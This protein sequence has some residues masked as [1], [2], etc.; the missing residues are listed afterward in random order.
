MTIS[1]YTLI[2][3]ICEAGDL[4]LYQAIRVQNGLPVLLKVPAIQ[5][6]ASHIISRL[7]NEYELA[8]DLDSSHIAKP[9]FLERS[10][11]HIA[12]VL[13][14]GPD[15]TLAAQLDSPMEIPSFLRIAIGITEALSELHRHD[16]V[17]KDLKP[18]HVL[19]DTAGHV[20]LTGLGIA[21]R[22][23]S[24]RQAPEP[25]EAIA[26]TLAYMAPE[27]TGRM[28]RLI[29]F[30]SDLYSLGVI[31]YQ[32]LT[33][34][35]P[36][37]ASDAMEWV[38]CHIARKP[39][40]P[41]QLV[42]GLPEPLSEIVM[43]L[44]AKTAEERY[45][46]ADGLNADLHHSLAQWESF[47]HIDHFPLGTSD[48]S[49]RLLIPEK[50]YGRK[51]E[52]DILMAAFDR[53]ASSGISELV[54]V[55][56]YSG[57]GKTSI[58]HELHKALVA[59]RGLFAEGKYEQYKRDV[60]YAP[61]VQ[62]IQ[63]LIR[64]ILGKSETEV[65]VWRESL[66][67]AVGPNGQLIVNLIPEVELVIG[68]QQPVAELPP[69][70]AQNR[71]QMVLR[72]FLL[73]FSGS[74]HPL[75]IFLDDLQW[76]DAATLELLNQIAIGLQG[77]YILLIGAYRDNEADPEHPLMRTLAALR[78]AGAL[79]QEIV[80]APLGI[81]DVN[82]LIADSL[83]CERERALPLAQLVHEKTGGNPFFTIQFLTMLAEEKLLAFDPGSRRWTW[84]LAHINAKGYTDNVV[85]LIDGK[86]G[87]LPRQ[88]LEALELLACLGNVADIATLATVCRQTEETLHAA[89]WEAVHAGLVFRQEKTYT[90]LHDRVQEAAYSQIPD[91][92]RKSVHWRIGKIL[93]GETSLKARDE[94]YFDIVNH[95][96]LGYSLLATQE[97]TA[98]LVELNNQAGSNAKKSA[99]FATAM[100]YF[101]TGLSLLGKGSWQDRYFLAL[102]LH[103]E[104]AEAACLCGR[105]DRLKELGEAVHRH[106][107]SQLDEIPMYETEIRALTAQGQLLPAI[108]LGLS[109]L[110]GLG[111]PLS[112]EPT[113]SEV[114]DHLERTLDLLGQRTIEG[115]PNL[116]PMTE[117][118]QLACIRILSVLGEPAYA[119]SPQFFLVWASLMAELSLRYGNGPLSPFAYAAYALALCAS[120]RHI[121][122]GSNL[123][124]TALALIEPMEARS[125]RCRLLN[126]YGCT[127]QPWSENL[128]DTLGTLQEAID[129]GAES[130]DFTS[131]SYA[132][133]NSCTAALFM[134][135]PLDKL[136]RRLQANMAIIAGMGQTYI[137]NW[138]AF[139]LLAV[140]RL[141]GA[142]DRPG[143]LGPFD[144]GRWLAAATKANDRCGLAY[145][146]LSKL[147][148]C[149]LLGEANPGDALTCLEGIKANQA[150]FQAAFAVPV[151]YFFAS[152]TLLRL[153]T[154]PSDRRL[155]DVREYRTKLEGLARLAPM[156][157]QHKC[158]LLA[159]ELARIGGEEW[160][161]V[162][163][164]EQAIVGARR[165]GFLHEEAICCELT[166]SF[167]SDRGL[168][169]LAERYIRSA[170]ERY[171]D[172]QAWAK[173]GALE[174]QYP[175]WL[176]PQPG[177][178]SGAKT[179]VLDLNT[180]MKAA[181]T[182]SSEIEMNRLLSEMM[183]IVIENAGARRGYLLLSRN[184]ELSLA[185]AARVENQSVVMEAREELDLAAD[186]L[187]ASILNY[188]GRS[189]DNVL[190]DDAAKPN[191]YSSD[192]YFLRQHPKSVLCFPVVK[193]N[194]LIGMLYLENDLATHAFTPDRLAVLE[195]IVLQAAISLEN[196]L[197]YEA[198]QE[199]EERLKLTLEATQIGIFD[200]DVEQ[201]QWLSSPVYYSMLGYEP[202]HGPGD[203][204]EWLERVHPDD[205][206]FVEAKI[207]EALFRKP[208]DGSSQ[209]YE[210]EARIRHADGSYRWQLV[211]SVA[212]K[213]D[214][215]GKVTRILGI[216]MD[217][218]DRKLMEEALFFVAQ[219]GWQTS[220]ENFFDALAQF[221]GE[222]LDM[223]YVFIDR[224]DENPDM[225]ETVALYA[226]GAIIPNM[227][228]AL[229]GTP[230]ENVMGK[231]LCVY[232]HGIQQ[233]FPED[234][235][236]PGMGAESYIGIPLWDS[237]GQPIG[238]IAVMDTKP[239]TNEVPATQVLQLVATRAA[240]ELERERSNCLLRA[241]EHEFRTLAENLPDNIMRYDRQGRAV[242]L[243]PALEKL[244]G[245]SDEARIGKR[246]REFQTDGRY[247][248]YAQA[249]DAV[250]TSGENG[251]FELTLP[252]PSNN[253]RVYQM[254]M[255]AERDEHGEVTG[256]LV[257]G[258]DI[259]ERKQVEEELC[260]LT[261]FQQT[262]LNSAPYSIISTTPDGM[263]T[264]FNPAAERLLGYAA[265]EVV[266]KQ[267]PALWHDRQEIE[268][269]AQRL[270]EELGETIEPGFEVFTARPCRSQPEE[271]EW[272][273]IHKNGTRI[274]VNLSIT[275]LRDEDGRVSGYLGM[276]YDLTERKQVQHQ[277]QLLTY[278]LDQVKET[279]FLM[280]E[281]DPQFMYVNQG[282]ARTLGYSRDELMSGMG[283]NDIDPSWSPEVSKKYWSELSAGRQ[284]Q[285]ESTHRT[286][287][288]RVFPVEITSNCF[289]FNAR[290][291]NL[292]ICRD[293]TERKQ[294]E[295]SLSEYAAII[296]STDDA[297][298]GKSLDGVITSWNKGAERM[299]GYRADEIVGLSIITL[300]PKERQSEEQEILGKIRRGESVKHYET[301][302]LC[303]DGCLIDVSITVSP[304]KNPL[305]EIIGA[306][307][308]ARDIT[309][310]KRAETELRRYRDQL[311][312]T[313]QQRTAE[314]LL[315]RDAAEAANKAKSVFL[316]N[317]SHELRTPLNAILGFSGILIKKPLLQDND[318]R[319][320]EIINH[321]GEH[322]LGLI[323]EVLEMAKIEAGRLQL[324]EK[325]F[326]LGEMVLNVANMMQV[327]AVEKK[328][329]LVIDQ[330]SAFPR[331][332]V[333][334]Q[335]R[336]RQV[337]INLVGNA[338][339]FTQR[340]G[341][342]IRLSTKN[343]AHSHLRIE[344]EDSGPGIALE[345][346]Q[347]IFEPFVQIG[348]QTNNKGTGLGL[349]ITRQFV[350][351]M[352]GSIQLES[353][354]GKGS[355]F[356]IDLPLKQ[357]EEVDINYLQRVEEREVLGLLPGQD[358]Y[359][360]LIVEDQLENRLLLANLMENVGIQVKEAEN[361]QAG[362]A[363][364]Q[365]WHP[366][367][368]W[369]DRQMPVMDGL[370]ATKIIRSLPGGKEVKIVAV[371]ASAFTEQRVD[372]LAAGMDDF[373]RKPFRAY[374]IYNCLSKQLGVQYV[375]A[376]TPVTP[377]ET[378]NLTPEML[379][380]L[381]KDILRDLELAV[382]NLDSEHIGLIIQQIT[383]YDQQLKTV[384]TRLADNYDY[385]AILKMLRT[386]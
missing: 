327:R 33:G 196:A 181:H 149:Y 274:P 15:R 217:V 263:V 127:I 187:P 79:V 180:V 224:L 121:E 376:N 87:R 319:N 73:G 113:E 210:Y 70:E 345:D 184:G 25:P 63:A 232:R 88:T 125:L 178:H 206:A 29:D 36:F 336:L 53:V 344:V 318:R 347:R 240:A 268:Q 247:E 361:G 28:N 34:V 69:L 223:D 321:S 32:M 54:L 323:N 17:H 304:L 311:E 9:L 208:S 258:R 56:G 202:K 325:P 92:E 357:V 106:V 86:I 343:N 112:E 286:R 91:E 163:L 356:R 379:S 330:S 35:L 227:R 316:A 278:A 233:L 50:L 105:Y 162:R 298:F 302:R 275:A 246:I 340:G 64:Q 230:C 214:Q 255:N 111:M 168:D 300:I 245:I 355:L 147:I 229:K 306:S 380:V 188:V 375:Y 248:A 314:L 78:K 284:M 312:D 236:L 117:P 171:A 123:A 22:L 99:A 96:N 60:P 348:N 257:I 61:F 381:P 326:D 158:D 362:V 259:T 370:E 85:E 295:K 118:H 2:A 359:R 14:P 128:R 6:P 212:L 68:K 313:V 164:Y 12:L 133:F 120:G 198:S 5:H 203:R 237:T 89:L 165:N 52:I 108:R 235:L 256:V 367:L 334:D 191:P 103:Q 10:A 269:H 211:K 126:I 335:A 369:M 95:L 67:Q 260:Q 175:R 195:L 94:D 76:L 320:I 74:G 44:L 146:F 177:R 307:K 291:Y 31:F 372:I 386:K 384:L 385:P 221:L 296:E 281:N 48:W 271:N 30:R 83:F 186:E 241:R 199:S 57:V 272:T 124:R 293:I 1:G 84:E 16:L 152:L 366:H 71:F 27:Q 289:E 42:S 47:G 351:L 19:L 21:S 119:A 337:L 43:K 342:T 277:L 346:Q 75:V 215:K 23:P 226:K 179:G 358:D 283:V 26:G 159:A 140:Q 329:Q 49:E 301:V 290:I 93:L 234:T 267:T 374:E 110:E 3:P 322:L 338:L 252:D 130:G 136:N 141:Q 288:G 218:T 154:S 294:T 273:F 59:H 315:A 169:D 219:R 58:I 317:M 18:E 115:I 264:A 157:F 220:G 102:T 116:P 354:L 382:K 97:E 101:E 81:D 24:E 239:I 373:I 129:A 139:H 143:E 183:R 292:A 204:E 185:A 308:I 200:W 160:R 65:A 213:S 249:V 167:Y 305:G 193:Q 378:V 331:Y 242:Y 62:A 339:K 109:V 39:V 156:N 144:E 360:I 45:Q 98:E 66:Q 131:S 104:A 142:P 46:S 170:H 365:S 225:A 244:H 189:L 280:R 265:D 285:F 55:S 368:I 37:I 261:L 310:R 122:M 137:W 324:D 8:R 77:S 148:S 51:S 231:A 216:R 151:F 352:K 303:K 161:A 205:R 250:L 182:I 299:Y 276:I 207:Q 251:E 135:E 341:V 363:L 350:Q 132:A 4:I 309:A 333:G 353:T 332:I 197:I 7:E 13:E 377:A 107:A 153:S 222:K 238:L 72:R 80:L 266:G 297:I 228:Y 243:N 190:L 38:H 173:V 176:T 209:E 254:R 349:S 174:A 201:D 41:E 82:T 194:K 287:D 279:I 114:G 155:D 262:I 192:E 328:L 90:F 172:W 40:S 383:A 150:G 11:G 100:Q 166:A 134:G 270:S 145:H 253:R 371:T 282:T 20:W 138:A 364:F